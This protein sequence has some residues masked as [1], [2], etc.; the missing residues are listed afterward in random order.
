MLEVTMASIL[1]AVALI[2]ALALLRDGM[3]ASKTIDDRQL[4]TNYAVSLLEEQLA[5]V[6]G[7]WTSG[8]VTGDFATD[9]HGD[10]RYTAIRSD[11]VVD[12]GMVDQLMHIQV[13]TYVDADGDDAL[14]ASE[15]QCSFRTKVGKFATY[16]DLATP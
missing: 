1:A 4:L 13:T 7:N 8:A 6:A 16:E 10:I 5:L 9:G 12:G 15:K 2:G 14:D 3:A 11:A